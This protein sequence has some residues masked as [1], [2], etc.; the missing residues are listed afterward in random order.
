MQFHLSGSPPPPASESLALRRAQ[1]GQGVGAAA[2]AA[3]PCDTMML[4]PP[5]HVGGRPHTNAAPHPHASSGSGGLGGRQQGGLYTADDAAIF[6]EHYD[7]VGRYFAERISAAA[8]TPAAA[9]Q[10]GGNGGSGGEGGDTPGQQGGP[11]G[12]ASQGAPDSSSSSGGSTAAAQWGRTALA[13]FSPRTV[14]LLTSFTGGWGRS[15]L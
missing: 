8:A 15:G 3:D 10:G 11:G 5:Q 13:R 7:A 12:T 9:G 6:R 2:A 14:E 1:Q 4:H